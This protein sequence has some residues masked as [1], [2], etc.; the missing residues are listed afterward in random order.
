MRKAKTL[1]RLVFAVALLAT[2]FQ[3][4][5]PAA[6]ST[7]C[8]EGRYKLVTTGPICS[9]GGTK[10]PKDLYQ[11]IN[12]QWEYLES[13]CGG[14][15]CQGSGGGG[16]GGC[17]AETNGSCPYDYAEWGLTCPAYCHCCY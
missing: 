8:I 5:V 17:T 7:E 4:Q 14:P 2:A 16:G 3:V 1:V 6:Q 9:C 12:G 10:T 11:C 15:F 13:L